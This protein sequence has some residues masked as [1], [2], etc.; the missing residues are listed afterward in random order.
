MKLDAA[1]QPARRSLRRRLDALG[2]WLLVLAAGIGFL[3]AVLQR[4]L[5]VPRD[6]APDAA[7]LLATLAPV[8]AA[9]AAGGHRA[10]LQRRIELALAQAP[11][12]QAIDWVGAD[13][14]VR[15]STEPSAVGRP[16]DDGLVRP[17]TRVAL[18]AAEGRAAGWLVAHAA[19]PP[20]ADDAAPGLLPATLALAIG[21]PLLALGLAW[22]LPVDE[23]RPP[24]LRL[25]RRRLR[26]TR[27]RL[28]RA[29]RELEWLDA[30]AQTQPTGVFTRTGATVERQR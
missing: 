2:P 28:G 23:A 7:A 9:D 4:G 25:A 18:P 21:L 17:G 22:A 1:G 12:M 27:E 8:V 14:Q 3:G 6:A 26:A 11:A 19:V 29:A 24:S 20:A 16:A 13:G 10:A 30:S 15:A 5:A